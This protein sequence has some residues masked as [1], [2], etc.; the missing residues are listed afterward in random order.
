MAPVARHRDRLQLT[1]KLESKRQQRGLS[2]ST[3]LESARERLLFAQAV[4]EYGNSDWARVCRLL[5]EHPLL[6]ASTSGAN[7]VTEEECA[8]TYVKLM[9][10]CELDA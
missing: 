9:N 6:Q 5:N 7:S 3:S 2:M 1:T 10:E 8:D 4:Y